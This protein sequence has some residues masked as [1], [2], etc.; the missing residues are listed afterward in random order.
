MPNRQ[1]VNVQANVSNGTTRE[2]TTT[3]A[4]TAPTTTAL[5]RTT[6]AT[7]AATT[8]SSAEP[9]TTAR[10]TTA[11][12]TTPK[13]T[14]EVTTPMTTEETTEATT[15]SETSDQATT[16]AEETTSSVIEAT[17][18]IVSYGPLPT[19]TETPDFGFYI[20]SPVERAVLN[21]GDTVP[22]KW[23]HD[24]DP[25]PENLLIELRVGQRSSDTALT[26]ASKLAYTDGI[27][28]IVPSDLESNYYSI[29]MMGDSNGKS[30]V[31][32]SK[33][34]IIN[35]QGSL[36]SAQNISVISPAANANWQYTNRQY[37]GWKWSDETTFFPPMVNIYLVPQKTSSNSTRSY[38]IKNATFF[39]ERTLNGQLVN[40][41]DFSPSA[42]LPNGTYIVRIA[43]NYGNDTTIPFMD[44]GLV[45]EGLSQ[46]FTISQ[47]ADSNS[48]LS[49]MGVTNNLVVC[50]FASLLL[51][52][53]L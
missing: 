23:S 31:G 14:A 10:T 40:S 16:T 7:S 52:L 30:V 28:W 8:E 13:T 26:I 25:I 6:A 12:A 51:T 48:A 17:T 15:T 43:A 24:A 2:A 27:S 20:S 11:V 53:L 9:E 21:A 19:N 29:W 4:R 41:T 50:T 32:R 47:N 39:S 22:I 45:A 49:L 1:L 35:G 42:A 46:T 3:A 33:N 36:P 34:F 37:I 38:L 44:P 18:S 5:V